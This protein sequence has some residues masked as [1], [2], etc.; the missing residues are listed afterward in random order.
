MILEQVLWLSYSP[1]PHHYLFL[2]PHPQL[3]ASYGDPIF[4][5]TQD[6]CW[7]KKRHQSLL[8]DFRSPSWT[9]TSAGD[10]EHHNHLSLSGLY[11]SFQHGFA[12]VSPLGVERQLWVPQ[13]CRELNLPW[14]SSFHFHGQSSACPSKHGSTPGDQ[15]L[16]PCGRGCRTGSPKQRLINE[17][18]HS[19]SK[20]WRA[21]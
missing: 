12:V 17:C 4:M 6:W 5:G 15:V 9:S 20:V 16:V 19:T 3:Q 11:C 13:R 14:E 21:I 7:P 1:F 2:L 10:Y 8:D 18:L